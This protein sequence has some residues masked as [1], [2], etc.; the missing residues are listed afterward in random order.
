MGTVLV[1]YASDYGHTKRAAAEV[2]LGVERVVGTNVRLRSAAEVTREDV[3]DADGLILGSP[4]HMGSI[5]WELKRFI[6]ETLS[7]LWN[8][9]LMVGRVG[10]VFATG[11]GYGGAGGGCELAM[12]SMLATLAELGMVIVPL[13]KCTES[14]AHGGL[15]WGPYARCGSDELSHTPPPAE[16]LPLLMAHGQNVARVVSQLSPQTAG[17]IARPSFTSP[18]T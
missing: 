6:D 13:P 18:Q 7:A 14:Y 5:H 1:I 2:A 9:D 12:L 17:R 11:G 10:G 16:S 3:L 4:V 15:H 8:Q